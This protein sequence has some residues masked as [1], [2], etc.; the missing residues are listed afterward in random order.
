M[1]VVGGEREG[2]VGQRRGVVRRGARRR[3][4]AECFFFR[5]PPGGLPPISPSHS[6]G[7]VEAVHQSMYLRRR[8]V[9]QGWK[10]LGGKRSL[11]GG[12]DEAKG[13]KE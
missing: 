2:G 11:T 5:R 7:D 9:R 13:R 8:G 12:G 4:A 3:A 10:G 1:C 6:T